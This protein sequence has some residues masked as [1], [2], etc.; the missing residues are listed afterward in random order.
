MNFPKDIQNDLKVNNKKPYIIILNSIEKN[1]GGSNTF[2]TYSFDWYVL[3]DQ[4]YYVYFQFVATDHSTYAAANI[5]V[6]QIVIDLGQSSN[7]F[8]AVS[9]VQSARTSSY[10]Q[11]GSQYL[12]SLRK[13]VSSGA[14][15]YLYANKT[16]NPPI[17]INGRPNNPRFLV[18]V[19]TNQGFGYDSSSLGN[20]ILTL[21]FEPA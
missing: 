10:L 21:Y 4:P 3:P 19:L 9:N 6:A 7:T 16:D 17:Y 11:G 12:G 14:N 20:Y 13:T 18:S 1:S 5:P 15:F 2:A 8:S